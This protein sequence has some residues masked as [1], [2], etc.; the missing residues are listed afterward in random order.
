[1]A[2]RPAYDPYNA[3]TQVFLDNPADNTG[4][5]RYAVKD[6]ICTTRGATTCSSRIL[7]AATSEGYRSP[8]NATCI[9]LLDA[10]K[11]TIAAKT[12]MDEF[13]MGS[14]T[15]NSPYGPTL[16]PHALERTAGGSSGGSAAALFMS[17]AAFPPLDFALGTDT[18]GSVR[19]PASYC[20]LFGF[21][22][23]YGRLSRW[24]VVPYANSLDTVG[25]MNSKSQGLDMLR[26]VFDLLNKSDEKDPTSLTDSTRSRIAARQSTRE[27]KIRIGVPSEYHVEEIAT[28]VL[29]TWRKALDQLANQ[30]CE[31][32][33]VPL[34]L[35][36]AALAAY[37]VLAPSEA[38]SNLQKYSGVFYGAR[39]EPDRLDGRLYAATR[40]LFGDEV[41]RRILMGCFSLSA[42]S[43]DNYYLQA[44]RIRRSIVEDFNFVFRQVHPL[45]PSAQMAEGV[46]YLLCPVAPTV[47]PLLSEISGMTSAEAHA[48][49]VFTVPASMAG[50]PALSIPFG[51]DEQGLPIGVQ[52][53]GQY[54]DDQGV[55]QVASRFC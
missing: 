11:C 32:V 19:I 12:N 25:I 47:A 27:G 48:R 31:I 8:F 30:D 5:L 28:S 46:D 42:S 34:P 55:L 33:P 44:Q 4:S 23:S 38:S 51:E 50:V 15:T 24:G 2:T 41:K 35:T 22:P 26:K 14:F 43:F 6:N 20:G 36:R 49:D 10:A 53:I 13:G 3:L 39:Q 21:K 54:G 40:D 37:Y 17:D 7:G 18:G 52:L 45:L 16:N 9:E 1:M 29:I